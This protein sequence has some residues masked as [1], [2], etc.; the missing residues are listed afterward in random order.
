MTD[1]PMHDHAPHDADLDA[2]QNV[3]RARERKLAEAQGIGIDS[4]YISNFVE[5]FYARIRSGRSLQNEYRIGPLTS[6]E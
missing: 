3:A 4:K 2:Q 5:H 6:S 1:Q